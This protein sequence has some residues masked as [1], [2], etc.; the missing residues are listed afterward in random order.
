MVEGGP[1][2]G[3]DPYRNAQA[4]IGAAVPIDACGSG[5]PA[6]PEGPIILVLAKHTRRKLGLSR[7]ADLARLVPSA[8]V[9]PDSRR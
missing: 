1:D 3:V 4:E 6:L 9:L 8:G 2:L 7:R 5:T